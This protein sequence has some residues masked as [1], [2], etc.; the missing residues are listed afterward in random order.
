MREYDEL[1]PSNLGSSL[2]VS[3]TE[4]AE[5]IRE[6]VGYGGVLE[7][8]RNKPDGMPRKILDSGR[9]LEMGWKPSTTLRAGLEA[10][11]DWWRCQA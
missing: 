2:D 6:V 9:L 4:L 8:D 11:F 1:Q 3:I 10:T 7:F 5:L